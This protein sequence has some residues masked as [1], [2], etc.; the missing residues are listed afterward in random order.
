MP[1]SVDAAP[2][3]V[4]QAAN[5]PVAGNVMDRISEVSE[6]EFEATPAESTGSDLVD[7]IEAADPSDEVV[8]TEEVAAP[9]EEVE[10]KSDTEETEVSDESKETEV[11]AAV[12]L[13]KDGLEIPEN[14]IFVKKVDGKDVE[15][16][17]KELLDDFSGKTAVKERFAE[18]NTVKQ[19]AEAKEKKT[20]AR[21]KK[22]AADLSR[23]TGIINKFL[24]AAK[25]G[26]QRDALDALCELTGA[27]AEK[28]W[29]D[30]QRTQK[31]YIEKYFSMTPEERFVHEKEQDAAYWK[32]QAQSKNTSESDQLKTVVNTQTQ[33]ET[34]AKEYGLTH[35]DLTIAHAQMLDLVEQGVYTKADIT[36]NAV[37]DRALNIK[38]YGAIDDFTKANLPEKS[39]DHE[40]YMEVLQD[41]RKHGI[42]EAQWQ[43]LLT[44]LKSAKPQTKVVTSKLA[45]KV[46]KNAPFTRKPQVT[47]SKPADDA[48]DIWNF[49]DL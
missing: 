2:I 11:E 28:T 45:Q 5:P 20:E 3:S 26:Q 8:P 39:G 19:R 47:K 21:E 17:V 41:T 48:E 23:T 14:S 46:A 16:T 42:T 40:F 4:P 32:R 43:S 24:E 44:E 1:P 30:H 18:A 31:E 6:E 12:I 22:I 13:T 35:T 9:T 29:T 10:A 27:D 49:D 34:K 36:V 38:L 7:K 33:L 15:V 37:A 25:S